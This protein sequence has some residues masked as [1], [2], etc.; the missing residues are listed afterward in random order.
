MGARVRIEPWAEGDLE[1]LRRANA[2]AMM[3][4]LGGPE[5]EEQLLVRHERYL[6][7]GSEGGGMF[8]IVL[9]P[10][11]VPAGSIG[12]WEK[13]WRGGT[14]YET[15]WGVLPEFQGRGVAAAAGE[16]VIARAAAEKGPRFLHAF[17]KVDN[18]PSNV[19]CRKLGFTLVE[20]C[21]FE[22]PPG[23]PIRCNDWRL[24]L[25]VP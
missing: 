10:E 8:S 17:P 7:S 9:L 5:T 4:H 23:H 15:G 24:E 16:A 14:V 19:I 3:R 12:Y 6:T 20:E 2:P 25:Y 21:D 22:Y 13:S 18:H 11:G 1:L